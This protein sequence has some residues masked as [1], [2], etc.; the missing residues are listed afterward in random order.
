MMA[1]V[2]FFFFLLA[3]SLFSLLLVEAAAKERKAFYA[4][5][6]NIQGT[7]RTLLTKCFSANDRGLHS[8]FFTSLKYSE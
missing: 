5:R 4:G 2:G 6:F 8:Y 7:D 1:L 3:V